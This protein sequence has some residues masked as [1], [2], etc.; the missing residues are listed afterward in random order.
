MKKDAEALGELL[1]LIDR[2]DTIQIV[3][4]KFGY[5]LTVWRS[6]K[7]LDHTHYEGATL[8]EAINRASKHNGRKN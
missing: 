2:N 4:R 3:K 8:I 5:E 7:P 1:S 6:G